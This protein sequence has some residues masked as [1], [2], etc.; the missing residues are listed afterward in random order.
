MDTET[1]VARA[2]CAETCAAVGEAP[3]YSH[4]DDQGKPLPWP[5]PACDD[6]GCI[7]LARAAIAAL[8]PQEWRDDIRAIEL[9]VDGLNTRGFQQRP[10][11]Q[12]ALDRIKARCRTALTRDALIAE[13]R[14]DG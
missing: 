13:E 10:E 11:T 12:A 3:C 14:T 2:I 4:T 5:A 8:P 9:A 6:P 7:W 1:S